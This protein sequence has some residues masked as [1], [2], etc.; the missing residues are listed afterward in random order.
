[1]LSQV[2]R[3]PQKAALSRMRLF[4][5]ACSRTVPPTKP[6][7]SPSTPY[8]TPYPTPYRKWPNRR[9]SRTPFFL[10]ASF[11]EP[12]GEPSRSGRN[13]AVQTEH[14]RVIFSR[15]LGYRVDGEN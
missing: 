7:P 13:E 15:I 14:A 8:P 11:I 6:L 4:A 1:M 5:F 3:I 2:S 9:G 10:Q 12:R